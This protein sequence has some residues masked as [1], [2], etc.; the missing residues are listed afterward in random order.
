[1]SVR[2]AEVCVGEAVEEQL[3][4]KGGDM[5]LLCDNLNSQVADPFKEAIA[6]IGATLMFG[7]KGATHLWQ[8]IDHHVGARY[9]YLMAKSYDDWMVSEFHT[10]ADGKIPVEKRRTLLTQ[11][12]GD[13][14]RQLETEREECEKACAEDPKA[15]RSLFYRAFESTG[16][17]VTADGTGDDDIKPNQE[18]TGERLEKLRAGLRSPS[19]LKSDIAAAANPV[20]SFIIEIESDSASSDNSEDEDDE[21]ADGDSSDDGEREPVGHGMELEVEDEASRIRAAR[22]IVME[23]GDEVQL[24]DFN[25][26]KRI[27]QQFGQVD[28]RARY[29]SSAT[30]SRGRKRKMNRKSLRE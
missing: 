11:W 28:G 10:F 24:A 20:E 3:G 5:L 16:C 18:V 1:M 27:A 26:A 21:P 4:D 12:C 17:L 2:W 8:P 13:A 25:M 23:G 29:H 19:Q 6:T 7:A 30:S 15:K 14:Y 22:N 9:K